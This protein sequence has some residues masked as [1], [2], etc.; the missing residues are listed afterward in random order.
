MQVTPFFL[1]IASF[2]VVNCA[3]LT[4][5][6]YRCPIAGLV[7]LHFAILT[8]GIMSL[9]SQFFGKVNFRGKKNERRIAIT[10]DDGPDPDLTVEI[11]DMLDRYAT[12]ATFF[13]IGRKVLL[14]PHIVKRAFR[15]GHVMA[16][17]D[18]KHQWWS[19]FRMTSQLF[20]EIME[21]RRIVENVIGKKTLLYRPPMGL[22][23][24]HVPIALSRLNMECV[25]WSGRLFDSGNKR[26]KKLYAMH[27]LAKPGAVILL[28]DSLPRPENKKIF[29]EQ[30]EKLLLAI[31]KQGLQTVGV[32]ELLELKA[33]S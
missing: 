27:K 30:F 12:R 7:L 5:P 33:Y 26:T 22:M 1:W 23:N 4:V 21:A 31:Q 16:C 3:L 32:D 6:Q 20:R 18:L 14:H 9:R 10:F 25:G 28:H 2:C 13:V 19:N 15:A 11:L 24:P 17:H 29:L 8:W